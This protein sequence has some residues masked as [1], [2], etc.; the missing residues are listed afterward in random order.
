MKLICYHPSQYGRR[1]KRMRNERCEM[2]VEVEMKITVLEGEEK[3]R[4]FT[5]K[6][7]ADTEPKYTEYGIIERLTMKWN[8]IHRER[9]NEVN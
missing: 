8:Y 4:T 6:T 7:I 5:E 9:A 3:G 2:K 1:K